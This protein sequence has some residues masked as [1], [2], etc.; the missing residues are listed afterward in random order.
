VCANGE[1]SDG[2]GFGL[3]D[4]E[5]STEET[6]LWRHDSVTGNNDREIG[7]QEESFG[8]LWKREMGI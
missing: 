1:R 7:L 2:E 4:E 8:L 6:L 5:G 3:A